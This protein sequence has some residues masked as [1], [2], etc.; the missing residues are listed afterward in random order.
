MMTRADSS[1]AELED[2][3][4]VEEEVISRMNKLLQNKNMKEALQF[5]TNKKIASVLSV[6]DT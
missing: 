2:K 6:F 3:D 4:A 1:A 5:M